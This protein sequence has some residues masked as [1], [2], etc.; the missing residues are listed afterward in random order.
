MHGQVDAELKSPDL[1]PANKEDRQKAGC[2][3]ELGGMRR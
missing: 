1:F 2:S 3:E